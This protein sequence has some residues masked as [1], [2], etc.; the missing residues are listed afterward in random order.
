MQCT[1]HAFNTGPTHLEVSRR[2]EYQHQK[3]A[4]KDPKHLPSSQSMLPPQG[5]GSL[6]N[7]PQISRLATAEVRLHYITL[8]LTKAVPACV[9]NQLVIA[10]LCG[11]IAC[12]QGRNLFNLFLVSQLIV[13]AGP[14]ALPPRWDP[15]LREPTLCFLSSIS[16]M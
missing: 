16:K 5:D 6:H 14:C 11:V 4:T 9:C 7:W 13:N 2:H 3:R 8:T 12:A 15:H 1:G 10:L